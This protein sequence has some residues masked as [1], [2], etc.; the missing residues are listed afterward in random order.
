MKRGGREGTK[1]KRR[2][3]GGRGGT[4]KKRRQEGGGTDE[5]RA[6]MNLE[7]KESR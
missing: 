3:E 6:G 2:K 4:K 7:S 1:K 5:R